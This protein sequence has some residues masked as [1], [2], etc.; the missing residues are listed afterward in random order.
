MA[1]LPEQVYV[2]VHESKRRISSCSVS[3]AFLTKIPCIQIEINQPTLRQC[4]G[5]SFFFFLDGIL[6]RNL[7]SRPTG[8]RTFNLFSP[9]TQVSRK[10][11]SSM[12]NFM[13]PLLASHAS[14]IRPPSNLF[15][16]E[17]PL[18]EGTRFERKREPKKS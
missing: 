16:K 9:E 17:L 15:H 3:K 13:L 10:H 8:R 1:N 7:S 18:L 6:S 4:L 14:R 12:Y 11:K 5:N 2:G